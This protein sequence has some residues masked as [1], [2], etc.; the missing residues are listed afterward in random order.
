MFSLRSGHTKCAVAIGSC[1]LLPLLLLATLCAGGQGE[2]GIKSLRQQQQQDGSY[3]FAYESEDGSYREEVGLLNHS[4][5]DN[6]DDA[7]E[8]QL[9]VSGQYR[10]VDSQGQQVEVS[11]VADRDGFVPKWHVIHA[12]IRGKQ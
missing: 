10:Y 3:Y 12:E 8:P 11:Y 2:Q 6:D 9:E 1:S 5:D 4:R 7:A